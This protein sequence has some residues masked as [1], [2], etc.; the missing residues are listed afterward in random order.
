M[1]D[2]LK[3]SL[4]LCA[5]GLLKDFRPSESF[6]TDFLT[7]FKNVTAEEVNQEIFP[8]GTYSYLLQLI[9]VFLITDFLRYKPLIIVLG[10][11]GIAIWSMLLW[12]SGKFNL[13]LV[14][15]IYGTYC[16]TEIAYFTYIYAKVDRKHYQQVTSHT[17]AAILCGRFASATLAQL[18]VNY[19]LMNYREL[20]YIT[21]AAQILAT[22]WAIFLPPV[23]NSIYFNQGIKDNDE[24]V[25]E[26]LTHD[27]VTNA[28]ALIWM[29]LKTSYKNPVVFLWS[30]YY[31]LCY[32][33]NVQVI[34]YIQLLWQGIDHTQE[35]IWNGAVEA[36]LTILGAVFTLL[37]G[38][39]HINMLMKRQKIIIVL[40]ILSFAQGIAVVFAAQSS[41][42]LSCYIAYIC[43]GVLYCFGIT[44]AASEIAKNL[45]E[46]CF[47]LVFGLNTLLA[48]TLQTI[49]TLTVVSSGFKLSVV[50]QFYVYGA[51]YCVLGFIYVFK[52]SEKKTM[53]RRKSTRTVTIVPSTLIT[54]ESNFN[55]TS[56]PESGKVSEG[57][58]IYAHPRKTRSK[59]GPS[60]P[61]SKSM[62]IAARLKSTKPPETQ[63]EKE[64]NEEVL[65]QGKK[66]I[67][68]R[69]IEVEAKEVTIG[70]K[71][72]PDEH[73]INNNI[74]Q[75]PT[76]IY[77]LINSSHELLQSQKLLHQYPAAR[78]ARKTFPKKL[79]IMPSA[80]IQSDDIDQITT[81]NSMV[82]IPSKSNPSIT[83]EISPLVAMGQPSTSSSSSSSLK[84]KPRSIQKKRTP[85]P[86]VVLLGNDKPSVPVS[87]FHKSSILPN[88]STGLANAIAETII[89]GAPPKLT[90]RPSHPLR[91]DGT[92]FHGN[93][94]PIT[95]TLND[96]AHRMTDY[97][98]NLLK[99]TLSEFS[100]LHPE[101]TIHRLH[102][103]IEELN[104]KHKK[105]IADLK[106]NSDILMKKSM[107]IEKT[108]LTNE[109]RV[110]C[111]VERNRAI[112][113]A[114]ADTKARQW[115]SNC[116]KEAKF[117][118]C[119]NTSYCNDRCQ[120]Q[121]WP[122]HLIS[123]VQ[124]NPR[125]V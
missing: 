26:S 25:P 1:K 73:S 9:V 58:K 34:S 35:V 21:L 96:N 56:L 6:L 50:G 93:C 118:C 114:V 82:C 44:I 119:W 62:R 81:V 27:R 107:E 90:R 88:M 99:D 13:K 83:S 122:T 87:A 116:G 54:L 2:Y 39:F 3:I 36:I 115:C 104:D 106:R 117:Y 53:N 110:Q 113:L 108:R 74:T 95:R 41:T 94:G 20:N 52:G 48:L 12:T 4:V 72:E 55:G 28:F 46:E 23:N 76:E 5:F 15:F 37:A 78:K 64:T 33:L 111:E 109:I 18:L 70:V 66:C 124:N 120:Q 112:E 69:R 24:L 89:G 51:L 38:K 7:D 71:Q 97:F 10:T 86:S 42:L 79:P 8:V 98:K 75:R 103:E 121:H 43:F 30:L 11:S 67:K 49:L 84:L 45:F 16:A 31:S 80:I 29:H 61:T 14:E 47:G 123:C 32:G 57:R 91:S 17:R 63:V 40:V 125:P 77:S 65:N 22:I 92:G 101:A 102:I 60:E 105:E 68:R 19:K 85:V 59:S 100:H